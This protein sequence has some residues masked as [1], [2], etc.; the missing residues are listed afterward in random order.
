MQAY[1]KS[2]SKEFKQINAHQKKTTSPDLGTPPV[3]GSLGIK[4]SDE[5]LFDVHRHK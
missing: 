1:V 3:K 5:T 2:L 4:V